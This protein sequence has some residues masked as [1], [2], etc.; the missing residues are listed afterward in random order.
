MGSV[1]KLANIRRSKVR[2]SMSDGI[3]IEG[4]PNTRTDAIRRSA[5]TD[6]ANDITSGASK[7]M[8]DGRSATSTK[9]D[10]TLDDV[11]EISDGAGGGTDITS[12]AAEDGTISRRSRTRDRINGGT[13]GD[14]GA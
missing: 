2:N 11:M 3:T 5:I 4:F 12:D 6:D 7:F 9:A 14:V 13:R 1:K 8:R 10:E